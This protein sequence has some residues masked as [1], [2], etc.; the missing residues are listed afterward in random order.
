M[1][2]TPIA[3]GPLVIPPLKVT[4]QRIESGAP[5]AT[6]TPSLVSTNSGGGEHWFF[7]SLSLDGKRALLRE[8]DP[9]SRATFH[10]RVVD[11]ETG[12][13]EEELRLPELAK[14]PSATIGGKSTELAELEWM[15]A[16]PA[17]GR[18]LV[19]GARIAGAF[20]FGACGRLAAAANG[21]AIAFD[22]GDWLYTADEAGR[23]RRRLMDEAAYDP[24]FSADGKH[25]LFRRATGT[26][27]PFAKYELF[28]MPADLSAAP[29]VIPGTSGVRDRFFAHPDGTSAVAVATQPRSAK[30]TPDTC[31]LSIGLKPPFN[32]RKLACLDG[33]EELVDS[34]VSPKGKWAALSTKKRVAD[35][36]VNA[37]DPGKPQVG[38]L[39]VKPDQGMGVKLPS[40]RHA[41][42]LEWRLRVVS[43]LNGKVLRDE[44]EPPG[45]GLRAI[46]DTGLLVQ[47]GSL[48]IV[49]TNVPM[50]KWRTID[51]PI[52]LGHRGFFRSEKE[53][54]YVSDGSVSVIDVTKE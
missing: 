49:V 28:T 46:S 13:I 11:V 17:F 32:T 53:L 30:G 18:D 10:V 27:G 5:G 3:H 48:G 43:L 33:N 31:V 50:K 24:R 40:D 23:V 39:G 44:P 8:L 15:L 21:S 37:S 41:T 19:R 4:H 25:F 36:G 38:G 54:V 26:D 35:D 22:A 20:P 9:V 42:H 6:V 45:L 34:V 51:K 12:A 14:I 7:E 16:S 52:D 47:S 2:H 29:R 1:T